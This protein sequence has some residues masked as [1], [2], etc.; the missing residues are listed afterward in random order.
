[1]TKIE[2][3]NIKHSE[4][5]SQETNCYEASLYV[6]GQLWGKVSND[7]WGGCDMFYPV[8]ERSYDD[9][10]ALN[11]KIAAERE[12]ITFKSGD[13]TFTMSYT[14]ELIC[15]EIVEAFLNERHFTKLAKRIVKD[16]VAWIKNNELWSMP[17]KT[18]PM[19]DIIDAVTK[20]HSGAVILNTLPQDKI[21]E[22]LKALPA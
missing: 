21:I 10:K 14:V 8:A 7:G 13:E 19:Q 20:K 12:P 2:L 1:M 18:R 4:F 11:E 22:L 15:G 6:D 3:K 5:A 9:M 17:C 16:K